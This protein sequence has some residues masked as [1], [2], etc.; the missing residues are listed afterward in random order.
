MRLEASPRCRRFL[1]SACCFG[2]RI[3]WINIIVMTSLPYDTHSVETP[4]LVDPQW[5]IL[6]WR[7]KWTFHTFCLGAVGCE[8]RTTSVYFGVAL[9]A[10]WLVN[11]L[12]LLWAPSTNICFCFSFFPKAPFEGH[13]NLRKKWSVHL[14]SL[15]LP[16]FVWYAGL[17]T[18]CS[19][20]RY[21]N[22]K[23][24]A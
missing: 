4:S 13:T 18:H 22:H 12:F 17:E 5:N 6:Y 24:W 11:F 8:W 2:I 3:F 20:L 21:A 9:F 23:Y 16:G 15:Q 10:L 1:R 7:S 19:Y 14:I